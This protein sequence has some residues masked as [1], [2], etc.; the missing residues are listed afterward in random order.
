MAKP[1]SEDAFDA[2]IS[3]LM[4][5]AHWHAFDSLAPA[6]ETSRLGGEYGCR[7]MMPADPADSESAKTR[8]QRLLK[9]KGGEDGEMGIDC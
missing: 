9:H 4:M 3:A 6:D 7:L 1:E 2:A 5:D 8:V